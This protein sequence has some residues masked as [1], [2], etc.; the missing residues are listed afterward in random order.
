[1]RPTQ[2]CTYA[3]LILA[4]LGSGRAQYSVLYNF[5]SRSGDPLEP[6]YSGIIAQGRDGNL[7]STAPGGANNVGAVFKITPAGTLT[8]LYS[9]DTTH[10]AYPYGGLTLGMDGN[11]YGTTSGGGAGWGTVFKITPSGAL[12][13]LYNFTNGSD[14]A[15]PY[16]PPIQGT[17]GNFYGTAFGGGICGNCGTVY[18]ITPSGTFTSLYQFDVT[19]GFGPYAPLVQGTDG[20]FYGTTQDGGTNDDG[21][22]FKVTSAGKLTVLYNFDLTHGA[23]PLG[24]LVQGSDGNFYGTA[25]TGGS[26][27]NG[28]VFKITP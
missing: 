25:E 9:F 5:G 15:S 21:V 2:I 18:K 7:Y 27:N 13:V 6:F 3:L 10:G 12:T 14:G 26:A 22:V 17:D 19:H 4:L 8:T 11:F 1:M 16:A 28:V 23:L 20:N 24:P